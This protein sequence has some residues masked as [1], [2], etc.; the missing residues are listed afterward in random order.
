MNTI[1][2]NIL[3]GIDLG[4]QSKIMIEKTYHFAEKFQA[5]CHVLHVIE[6]PISLTQSFAQQ[7]QIRQKHRLDAEEK[8]EKLHQLI[9]GIPFTHLTKFGDPQ[10]ELLQAAKELR[11]DLICVGNQGIGG[12]THLLGSTAHHVLNNA[13]QDVL[14]FQ[15]KDILSKHPVPQKADKVAPH[16]KKH[17]ADTHWDTGPT[18]GS[19]KG[20]GQEVSKGPKLTNRPSTS[21]YRG[22]T[23]RSNNDNRNDNE[24]EET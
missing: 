13:I 8:F 22:G 14:I 2:H 5:K 23:R 24:D 19:E 12:T 10:I 1:Y 7:E 11:A 20:F 3:V 9:R 15:V 21:P 18:Y 16:G 17:T 4:P 6:H